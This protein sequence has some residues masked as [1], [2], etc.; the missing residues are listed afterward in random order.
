MYLIHV[1][2][3]NISKIIITSSAAIY[4]N[5]DNP[6]DEQVLQNHYLLMDKVN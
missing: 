4:Q 1:N 2:S 6:V 5:S 3:N